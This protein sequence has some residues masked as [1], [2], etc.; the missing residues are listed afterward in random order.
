M[1][2]KPPPLPLIP[3]PL[4]LASRR[5]RRRHRQSLE[6]EISWFLLVCA[7]D[8]VFT[9]IA[10]H[11]SSIGATQLTIVESNPIARF[12]IENYGLR[13]MVVFKAASA[14]VVVGIAL[15]IR[16]HRPLVSRLLLIGGTTVV[17]AVVVYTIRLL[18]LHR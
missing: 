16:P 5:A 1:T 9:H 15:L 10:L 8:V 2:P 12:V 6:T 13:G 11:L 14:L 18:L 4:P 17:G 3:P 7:L